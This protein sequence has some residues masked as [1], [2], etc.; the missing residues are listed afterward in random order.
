MGR[1]VKTRLVLVTVFV[2]VVMAVGMLAAVIVFVVVLLLA[3]VFVFTFVRHFLFPDFLL[4]F[5]FFFTIRESRGKRTM[6]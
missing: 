5:H 6:C 1:I 3:S 2:I 4:A